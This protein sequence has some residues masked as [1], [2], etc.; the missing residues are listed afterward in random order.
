MVIERARLTIKPGQ[1]AAFETIFPAASAIFERARGCSS[2]HFERVVETPDIYVLVVA[3][4]TIED[5]M[6]HFRGSDDFTRW[7]DLAGPYFAQA[8]MVEHL[9]L[10]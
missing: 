3:W 10:R 6:V 8:P 9:E 5:H 2:V 4:E 7:R 1:G